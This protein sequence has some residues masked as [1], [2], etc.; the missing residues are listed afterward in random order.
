MHP[1]CSQPSNT[2]PP[3]ARSTSTWHCASSC[4]PQRR[5]IG[6]DGVRRIVES[7]RELEDGAIRVRVDEA[8]A[9]LAEEL[10]D[11]ALALDR[12]STIARATT[13]PDPGRACRVRGG[14]GR[15]PPRASRRGEIVARPLAHEGRSFSGS[16]HR[17]GRTGRSDPPLARAP[18][19]RRAGHRDAR[20]GA[21]SPGARRRQRHRP[22]P[23][24]APGRAD[25]R[26]GGRHPGRTRRRGSRI[27]R[28]VARRVEGHGPP[29]GARG[30]G[31]DRHGA[32]VRGRPAGRS[33]DLPR[34]PGRRVASG[35]ARRGG[36]CRL[37]PRGRPGRHPR[38][39]GGAS[40]RLGD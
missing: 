27:G 4:P 1:G 14:T 9:N 17:E 33:P 2:E 18:D 7:A 37:P 8:A 11:Q 5:L 20:R 36:R 25:R 29:R 24:R 38:I 26:L 30:T 3:P 31:D 32:R 13:G 40:D 22:G 28:R 10:G 15:L 12:W 23:S 19:R 21:R 6:S 34:G 35:P 16:R 39:G